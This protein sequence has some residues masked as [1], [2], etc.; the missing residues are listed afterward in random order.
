MTFDQI[1]RL[2]EIAFGDSEMIMSKRIHRKRRKGWWMQ[3]N[4]VYVGRPTKWMP[5]EP[6]TDMFAR[7]KQF[8]HF[9]LL[10]PVSLTCYVSIHLL[11]GRL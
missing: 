6:H 8:R 2:N 4:T 1:N 10:P 11:A 3:P 9:C 5:Y 7:P